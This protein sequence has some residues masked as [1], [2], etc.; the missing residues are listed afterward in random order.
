V[1]ADR[2]EQTS[3][4]RTI[5]AAADHDKSRG[6]RHSGQHLRRPAAPGHGLH[7]DGRILVPPPVDDPGQP[8][9]S[10]GVSDRH[11]VPDRLASTDR[12]YR[13]TVGVHRDQGNPGPAG[14]LESG[15]DHVLHV[16]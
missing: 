11:V 2:A 9:G 16:R 4:D 8:A 12:R 15:L 13:D 7:L 3:G 5:C 6:G 1:Q 14:L 10:R